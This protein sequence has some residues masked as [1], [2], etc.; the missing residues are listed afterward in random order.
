VQRRRDEDSERGQNEQA[1]RCRESVPGSFVRRSFTAE[2]LS[3]RGIAPMAVG[4]S[5][6]IAQTTSNSSGGAIHAAMPIQKCKSFFV[7]EF[8]SANRRTLV[9]FTT[10]RTSPHSSRCP[11]GGARIGSLGGRAC[12]YSAS[13]GDRLPTASGRKPARERPTRGTP[14]RPSTILPR[15]AVLPRRCEWPFPSRCRRQRAQA[16][17]FPS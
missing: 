4:P 13:R 2:P 15:R 7:T 10:Y 5:Q 11:P 12:P 1:S 8:A 9:A 17:R 3:C 16:R 6:K 14:P